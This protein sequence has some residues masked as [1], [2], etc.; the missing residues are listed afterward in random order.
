MQDVQVEGGFLG[1]SL[2]GPLTESRSI[3]VIPPPASEKLHRLKS[4][5]LGRE[6]ASPNSG[7]RD[8]SPTAG[9]GPAAFV[10]P[11]DLQVLSA[12]LAHPASTDILAVIGILQKSGPADARTSRSALLRAGACYL[13]HDAESA[14]SAHAG[15]ARKL[16]RARLHLAFHEAVR[17]PPDLSRAQA[18]TLR[19][20]LARLRLQLALQAW[21]QALRRF[22]LQAAVA[23]RCAHGAD[24]GR[25]RT[26]LL[27][28]RE[29]A[30]PSAE[31][32]AVA[33]RVEAQRKEAAR[34]ASL[35]AWAEA[36]HLSRRWASCSVQISASVGSHRLRSAWAHW[37]AFALSVAA[38]GPGAAE[39][40]QREDSRAGSRHGVLRPLARLVREARAAEAALWAS[41]LATRLRYYA[42]GEEW[43]G[44]AS[45]PGS[46]LPDENLRDAY[47]DRV[48]C[49]SSEYGLLKAST[50]GSG[51]YASPHG[52]LLGAGAAQPAEDV[53]SSALPSL[54]GCAVRYRQRR[55]LAEV[56]RAL[57]CHADEA[58][59]LNDAARHHARTT[60]SRRA[61]RL[62]RE[63]HARCASLAA[64]G[65]QRR[66]ARTLRTVLLGWRA[67]AG[68][69]PS[70]RNTAAAVE[71]ASVRWRKAHLLR[72]WRAQ[73]ELALRARA[74]ERS[75]LTRRMRRAFRAW[76]TEASAGLARARARRM[77]VAAR[78]AADAFSATKHLIFTL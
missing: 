62:W 12:E 75:T 38:V 13:A 65:R 63:E 59:R 23:A 20:L 22:R 72:R 34:R 40:E 14:V 48:T 36:A 47:E 11:N 78:Y 3:N 33:A 32:L 7:D 42:G 68:R 69:A 49:Q 57:R 44:G 15:Q 26:A 30:L 2:G 54:A 24:A 18:E 67:E 25:V 74:L 31:A 5:S 64:S 6:R 73:A 43:A 27:G 60:L 1:R 58:R 35:R 29:M 39:P 56:L 61:L 55:L 37:R 71:A 70:L 45:S 19:P 16:A 51:M 77:E 50:S 4:I 8:E 10:L 46:A 28:W 9:S 76:R 52:P 53:G 66:A 17:P 41:D 21:R